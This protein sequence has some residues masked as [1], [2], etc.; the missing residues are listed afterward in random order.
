MTITPE[1]WARRASSFGAA[2]EAYA[3]GRPAYPVDA[4]KWAI[5]WDDAE[6][7]PRVLDLAAGTGKLTGTLLD[8]GCDVV[9]VEPLDDMRAYI[10]SGAT[11]L[12][13][14]AEQIPLKDGSVNAVVVGQAFHWFDVTPATAEIV[15]VLRPGGQVAAL[16]NM[17]DADDPTTLAYAKTVRGMTS[18]EHGLERQPPWP[19]DAGIVEPE[20][21]K[22]SG[23]ET[24]NADRLVA[25]AASHS[26]VINAEFDERKRVL[27]AVRS[28]APAGQFRIVEQVTVWRGVR[29]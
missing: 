7:R 22:F 13:G 8:L 29:A 19:A 4:V 24:Y 5:G 14:T 9:A 28:V 25:Y 3:Y 21:A 16:W 26:W 15:R 12:K 2:A 23:S 20:L 10:P 17:Y 18:T 1:E 6:R 27:D 11:A